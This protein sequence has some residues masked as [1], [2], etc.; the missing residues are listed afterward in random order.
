MHAQ[1]GEGTRAAMFYNLFPEPAPL[2]TN[3]SPVNFSLD[4]HPLGVNV[5]YTWASN[6]FKQVFAVSGKV[7]N[8]LNADGSEILINSCLLYTSPSP[9]DRTRTR[10]P[11][12]A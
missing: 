9:R 4:Q 1:E 7:T 2:L 10:M 5:G 12:S 11:S 3:T 8:G 6:Y